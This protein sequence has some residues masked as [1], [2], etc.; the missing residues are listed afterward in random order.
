[1]A[2][3][4]QD[5]DGK[6]LIGERRDDAGAWQFPQGGVEPNETPAAALEREL[7]EELGLAPARYAV[8][9]SDG[10]YRYLFPPGRTKHGFHGQEQ[11][12]F[13][14]EWRDP[15][16]SIAT[17]TCAPEFRTVRWIEPAEF[18]VEWLPSFKRE[19]YREVF[20]DFFGIDLS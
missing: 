11:T 19:V 15:D 3:I 10:P 13:L 1:M 7:N 2:A 6:I 4:L 12:Y 17:D 8:R 14:L 16:R 20:R 9:S 5:A 18:R